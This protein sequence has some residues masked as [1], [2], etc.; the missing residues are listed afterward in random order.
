MGEGGYWG[1]VYEMND[2]QYLSIRQIFRHRIT[3]KK[4]YRSIIIIIY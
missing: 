2:S 3:E 1:I 4:F